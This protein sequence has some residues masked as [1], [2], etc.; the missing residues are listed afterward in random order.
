MQ[1]KPEP[2]K[3]CCTSI[4]FLACLLL[5][6]SCATKT[7]PLVEESSNIPDGFCRIKVVRRN[8]MA[9]SLGKPFLIDQGGVVLTDKGIAESKR[10][11]VEVGVGNRLQYSRFNFF[12]KTKDDTSDALFAG[13]ITPRGWLVRHS[14]SGG[15][16]YEGPFEREVV[17]SPL[18]WKYY[19]VDADGFSKIFDILKTEERMIFLEPN[20]K[21]FL[22]S[23]FT[24]G[25]KFI[26][27][28][29]PRGKV[30]SFEA[31]QP[32]PLVFAYLD[33]THIG[34]L[35]S[36]KG[37]TWVRK[38]GKFRLCS[39]AVGPISIL[40]DKTTK[41]DPANYDSMQPSVGAL[42]YSDSTIDLKPGYDYVIEW[43]LDS[44]TGKTL[45]GLSMRVL[46][47]KPYKL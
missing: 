13:T 32:I 22:S 34:F 21:L 4:A 12:K 17:F 28:P 1:Y 8:Q 23:E 44:G 33:A 27:D 10:Y 6:I 15:G 26:K 20:H 2:F 37:I 45:G 42:W 24:P 3:L 18:I 29:V 47:E 16:M 46:L 9:G 31:G 39:L 11:F 36:D 7:A 14:R 38:P 40:G 30:F 25:V 35:G 19:R 43:G 41:I 5:Q